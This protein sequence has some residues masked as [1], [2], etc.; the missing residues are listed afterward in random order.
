MS[1]AATIASTHVAEI[2]SSAQDTGGVFMHGPTFMANPLACAV[3]TANSWRQRRSSQDTWRG[4]FA[5]GR[6]ATSRR[7]FGRS[8]SASAVLQT[9]NLHRRSVSSAN[10]TTPTLTSKFSGEPCTGRSAGFC[11]R[12]PRRFASQRAPTPLARRS[13][14]SASSSSWTSDRP[15][16]RPIQTIVNGSRSLLASDTS[17]LGNCTASR[18]TKCFRAM[19]SELECPRQTTLTPS[20]AASSAS[21]CRI[22]PV[23]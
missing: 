4:F 16:H 18:F 23:R 8:I 5:S 21:W 13:R 1:L 11:T 14:R 7:S 15:P 12:S 17:S 6:F 20:D 9:T 22:S 2:I 3:A 10:T 19:R